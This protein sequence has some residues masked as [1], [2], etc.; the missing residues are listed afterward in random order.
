MLSVAALFLGYSAHAAT[1]TGT[2][3]A[4]DTGLWS[5]PSN[6]S[7]G[8]PLNA[9]DIAQFTTANSVVNSLLDENVTLGTL[10]NTQNGN[11][12]TI[13]SDGTHTFTMSS[14]GATAAV[15]SNVGRGNTT[16][17]PNVVIGDSTNGLSLKSTGAGGTS[18][19]TF[20]GT[21]TGTGPLTM[22]TTGGSP[23][24]IVING[25]LNTVGS[26]TITGSAANQTVTLNNLGSNFATNTLTKTGAS[27]LVLG[28]S[29]ALNT[30]NHSTIG[31]TTNAMTLSLAAGAK[32]SVTNGMATP[33]L[34]NKV[35]VSLSSGEL[36][37]SGAGNDTIGGITA[38]NGQGIITVDPNGSG[39]AARITAGTWTTPTNG[40]VLFRGAN[41]GSTP[42]AGVGSVF[43]TT[44]P[45][46]SGSGSAGTNTV[47]IIT[48]AYGDQSVAGTGTDFVTYDATNG[49]RPLTA[50]EYSPNA[51]VGGANVNI[52][53]PTASSSTAINS[54]L[55]GAG[56]QITG[57]SAM[58]I[59]SGE[60][61]VAGTNSG[62][63]PGINLG[64]AT[65]NFTTLSDLAISG[66]I[67]GTTHGGSVIKNGSGTLTLNVSSNTAYTGT[68]TVNGGTL[69]LNGGGNVGGNA[70]VNNGGTIKLGVGNAF[71]DTATITLNAGG[72]FDFNGNF[73]TVGG[74]S[75]AGTFTDS[76][77]ATPGTLTVN[78]SN[79]ST[80]S[81]LISGNLKLVKQGTGT[82]V[83]AGTGNTYT[84]TTIVTGGT[85]Q[86]AAPGSLPGYNSANQVTI[87][88]GGSLI[89][90]AGFSGI[91]GWLQAD[92]DALLSNNAR[93]FTAGS[94]LG[95]DTT[96]AGPTFTYSSDIGV[97]ALGMVKS[98]PNTLVLSG[99]SSYGGGT[100]I[101]G[102]TL[103]VTSIGDAGANGNLGTGTI[104]IGSA[105]TAGTLL[106]TGAGESPSKI[107]D[108]SG[109]TGGAVI[110]QSGTGLLKIAN[111]TVSGAGTKILTLQGTGMGEISAAISNNSGTNTTAVTKTGTGTWTLSGG[112]TY[113][114]ATSVNVGTLVVTGSL[115][116]TAVSIGNGGTL[117]LP[118]AGA[119]TQNTVTLSNGGTLSIGASSAI[120][121][122][123]T[124]N[125]GGT[126][127]ST[128]GGTYSI[129]APVTIGGNF[130]V[131]GT[132]DLT[133]T[134]TTAIALSAA[135]T[136]TVNNGN[137]T[138][139]QAFTGANNLTKAGTGNLILNGGS[140]YTARTIVSGG[141]LQVAS[142]NS[143]TGGVASSGLGAP[144]TVANGTI[145][146]GGTSNQ[147][148]LIY[149]GAGE[150]TDRVINL[151]G[152]TGGG[153]LSQSG[154]GLLKFTSDFTATGAGIKT[155]TLQGSTSGTGEIDGK[156]VDNSS[157][158]KTSVVKSGTGKWTLAGANTYSGG[159]T[160]NGGTL[161]VN[162]STG[163]GA[164]T[165]AAG[166][167]LNGTGTISGAI[168]VSGTLSGSL[169]IGGDATINSG[170]TA[171]ASAFNG[172]IIDNGSITGGFSLLSGKSLSGL[173]SVSGVVTANT[174]STVSPSKNNTSPVGDLSVDTLNLSSGAHLN[175]QINSP[176]V[177][178]QITTTD[179]GAGM[180]LAGDVKLTIA[181]GFAT[182]GSDELF[183][184]INNG[185]ATTGL[186]AFSALT[187]V[188]NS[189]SHAYSSAEGTLVTLN[190]GTY[191][192]TY[193]GIANGDG[194]GNDV[195]LL[196]T[197]P[198]PAA[199][200]NL[201]CGVGLLAGLQRFRRSKA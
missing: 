88:S 189:G 108:L 16:I 183:L 48:H 111:M 47:G 7:G 84:G 67:G 28:S 96:N 89:V 72:T 39:N 100:T 18:I 133:F 56:G 109:T 147:G 38:A 101:A 37:Y 32:L 150:T 139:A 75:G 99:N 175:L 87:G 105:G 62:I 141:S 135:R 132:G 107:F 152:L 197:V 33:G 103:N 176:T 117:S 161:T 110:D 65:L 154:T 31:D 128:D 201:I 69:V 146:L 26:L 160:V 43:F 57:S 45:T 126:I 34:S 60:I 130:T 97:A 114:G 182:T 143:V 9:G 74:I 188:D 93:G 129:P 79:T 76:S 27:T 191:R 17:N 23:S 155:L 53:T 142:I 46:L 41:L 11:A 80:F 131:G 178:D 5:N 35:T 190:G 61:L 54:L 166:G 187:V 138:F 12:W 15:I 98:G 64:N 2:W 112:N 6:W 63:T 134:D 121:A 94:F 14:G 173:G 122:G 21:I 167:T 106:Y 162:S 102:G 25:L 66:L 148:T 145:D 127:L 171:T 136:I 169:T 174:G 125:S 137:T 198:E 1:I 82:L 124:L 181:S 153:A 195:A 86:V 120:F 156:I 85:L 194:I 200:G 59:S 151:A 104:H 116:N 199:I 115:G 52:T 13:A 51:F 179:T 24:Q 8:V 55:I 158:N 185:S 123:L 71:L 192:L 186:G 92:I 68:T 22:D 10:T 170:G 163:T 184:I 78:A 140:T 177:G 42:G 159:T 95:I 20:N 58:V 4:G 36:S 30:T 50:S 168:V 19:L 113:T 90:N 70:T 40:E 77:L 73:E 165:V 157:G 49:V 83:L 180:S 149:T 193:Q 81:G 91:S 164:V 3:I 44:A 172:N 196:A 144:V 118:I 119:I 29:L